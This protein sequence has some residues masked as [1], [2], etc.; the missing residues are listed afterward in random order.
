MKKFFQ[1][2]LEK[3]QGHL[4]FQSHSHHVW[5]DIAF[6]AMHEYEETV[7]LKLDLK[8]QDVFAR[9][10]P[11]AQKRVLALLGLPNSFEIS[12][13]ANTHELL[14]RLLSSLVNPRKS[15][16]IMTTAFEYHSARRLFQNLHHHQFIE[17][18]VA[19]GPPVSILESI[20]QSLKN[21]TSPIDVCFISQS[22]FLTGFTNI[23]KDILNLV[24]SFPHT[25]FVIDCYHSFA[26]RPLDYSDAP[27]NVSFLGGSY[28]YAMSGEGACY[29]AIHY[30]AKVHEPILNGWLAEFSSLEK[31]ALSSSSA[32]QFSHG[33]WRFMGATLDPCGLYRFV[34]VWNF[35][36]TNSI[37]PAK[38]RQHSLSCQKAFIESISDDLMQALC[39]FSHENQGNFLSLKLPTENN[40]SRSFEELAKRNVFVDTRTSYLRLGFGPY[41]DE[42]N[43]QDMAKIL[44]DLKATLLEV[45]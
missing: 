40:A 41:I 44:N 28:K 19:E 29:L 14:I 11:E 13:G 31:S 25:H 8:W 7:K 5:P 30:Q 15:L 23:D 18:S 37:S 26:A 43:S 10:I 24:K 21:S 34:S 6:S 39:V 42:Q 16:H 36:E 27:C 45:D 20:T 3:H 35:L 4:L 17:L 38:I 1:Q 9:I 2:T 32:L 33:F 22:Y 12:F